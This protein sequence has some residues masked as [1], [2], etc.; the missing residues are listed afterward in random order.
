MPAEIR[1]RVKQEASDNEALYCRPQA[2]PSYSFSL[3]WLI[4]RELHCVMAARCE[5][6]YNTRDL[7]SQH[8]DVLYGHSRSASRQTL[9]GQ[10]SM[11]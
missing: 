1:R 8:L 3:Q 11:H 4:H 5:G 10:H 2:A 6:E 7:H 9:S